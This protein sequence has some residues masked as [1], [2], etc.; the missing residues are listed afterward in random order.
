VE[1]D[2]FGAFLE[3]ARQI[4]AETELQIETVDTGGEA[5]ENDQLIASVGLTGELRGIFLLRTDS[6]SATA[7]ARAMTG[8]RAFL[9][10]ENDPGEL[11]LAAMGELANQI[12]GRATTILSAQQVSCDITP[13]AIVAAQRLTSLVPNLSGAL[14]GVI[15]GPF[16]RL[17]LF[18]GLQGPLG[19]SGGEDRRCSGEK[20]S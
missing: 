14:H 8:G 16:G 3:A 4:F 1:K 9:R 5:A 6:G 17:S 19:R 13:P 20:T 7:I 10:G 2:T 15:R 12:S 18:L 11:Q